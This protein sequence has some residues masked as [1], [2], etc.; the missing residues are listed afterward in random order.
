MYRFMLRPRWIVSHVLVL[1]LVVVM[2]NL[3]L[4]QLR[5]L[6]DKQHLNAQI[7]ART[8]LAPASWEELSASTPK[9]LEY[10]RVSFTGHF[11]VDDE[12]AVKNRTLNGAPGRQII[13]PLLVPGERRAI[14]VLRGWAPLAIAGV[15]APFEQVSPGT[16]TVTVSG[17]ILPT[18]PA[19]AIGRQNAELEHSEVSR[20]SIDSIAR[21]RSLALMPVYIQMQDQRPAAP[22]TRLTTVPLPALDDGPHFS[23]AMQWGIFS[24]IALLGYP[25]ILRK[26][27][28]QPYDAPDGGAEPDDR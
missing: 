12:V 8:H 1:A 21:L 16:G 6:H 28:R 13:T 5:R 7:V 10:R 26:V 15:D 14:L 2:V 20:I 19:P 17:W 3:G 11:E 23:Y 25:L 24:L 27:A 22:T 9:E 18:E 4:W